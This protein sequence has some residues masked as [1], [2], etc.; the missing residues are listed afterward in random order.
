MIY[1]IFKFMRIW[2]WF[3]L[4]TVIFSLTIMFFGRNLFKKAGKKPELSYL[5]IYNL[6]IL[7]DICQMFRIYFILLLLPIVNVLVILLMLYRISIVFH[8]STGFAMGLIFFPVIFLPILNM[9]RNLK[10]ENEPEPEK[11]DVSNEMLT[12][13]TEQQINDINKIPDDKPI[14]DNVFKIPVKETTPPPTFKANVI[15]YKQMVLDEEP[16][17]KIEKVEPVKVETIYENRF[18]NTESKQEEDETIE[19]VEL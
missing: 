3:A 19:I 13:L 11:V 17:E 16:E 12:V 18:I 1:Y 6:L 9:S 8:T 4:I 2:S 14:V 7:L 5:P 10:L 15:K